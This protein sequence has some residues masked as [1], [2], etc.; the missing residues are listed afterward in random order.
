MRSYCSSIV[1][2]GRPRSVASQVVP[3]AT[4]IGG[5]LVDPVSGRPWPW[6]DVMRELLLH[7]YDSLEDFGEIERVEAGIDRLTRVGAGVDVVVEAVR[8]TAGH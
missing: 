5:V 2:T 1:H 7:V 4:N 6:I 8:R 3:A